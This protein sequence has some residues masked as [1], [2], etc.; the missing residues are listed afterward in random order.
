M[1]KKLKLT[2]TRLGEL[3]QRVKDEPTLTPEERR[4]IK[5]IFEEAIRIGALKVKK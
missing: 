5:E 4:L 3:L 2:R 1:A